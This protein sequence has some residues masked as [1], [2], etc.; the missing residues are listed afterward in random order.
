MCLPFIFKH[1]ELVIKHF[2]NWVCANRIQIKTHTVASL[3]K[4]ENRPSLS[5]LLPGNHGPALSG[6]GPCRCN[7]LSP[8]Y[9]CPFPP[10]AYSWPAFHSS[11]AWLRQQG[12]GTAPACIPAGK[13]SEVL[14]WEQPHSLWRAG[15]A[16]PEQCREEP[17]LE[18]GTATWQLGSPSSP[19][20]LFLSLPLEERASEVSLL[21]RPAFICSTLSSSLRAPSPHNAILSPD[22]VALPKVQE[23]TH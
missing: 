20:H 22:P 13:G 9:H 21:F 2:K 6:R 15:R 23:G 10:A 7:K 4:S 3:E 8:I 12:S 14:H 11:G 16:G 18:Q 5:A 19:P 17:I 1:F